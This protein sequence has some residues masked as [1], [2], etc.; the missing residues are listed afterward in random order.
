MLRSLVGSEMCIRDSSTTVARRLA[1]L[2]INGLVTRTAYA[3][4]PATVEYALTEDAISLQPSLE[5]MFEWVLN[6]A[7]NSL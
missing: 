6:R 7:D 5:S 1:E 4:V 3:T 2:E